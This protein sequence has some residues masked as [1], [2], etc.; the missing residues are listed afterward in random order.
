MNSFTKGIN[1]FRTCE[2]F[3][4]YTIYKRT[5][6]EQIMFPAGLIQAYFLT[7]FFMLIKFFPLV[8]RQVV[9]KWAGFN[10]SCFLG[11]GLETRAPLVFGSGRVPAGESAVQPTHWTLLV[12]GVAQRNEQKLG[13][14]HALRTRPGNLL[15]GRPRA[16]QNPGP[17]D[18]AAGK[19]PRHRS[20]VS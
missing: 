5:S 16:L 10:Y 14:Q 18:H 13:R 9:K 15:G 12:L 8:F 1:F 6:S 3:K 19:V 2:W 17:P 7:T 11:S 20:Q 4:K